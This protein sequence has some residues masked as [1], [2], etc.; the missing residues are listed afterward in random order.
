LPTGEAA[1]GAL[2]AII[3][4]DGKCARERATRRQQT[5]QRAD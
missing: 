5:D 1:C 4:I 2:A 3:N